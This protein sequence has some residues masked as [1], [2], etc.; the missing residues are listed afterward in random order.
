MKSFLNLGKY[1]HRNDNRDNMSLIPN[2]INRVKSK[3]YFLCCLNT[4]CC[5]C[6]CI[7]QI[8]MNHN[9]TDNRSQIRIRAKY[10]RTAVC[11]QNWQECVC[12][13]TEKLCKR[14][15]RTTGID[16]QESIV[17]HEIQCFHNSHKETTCNDCRNDRNENITKSLNQSLYRICSGSCNLLQIFLTAL[18]NSGNLNKFIV[19]LIDNSC[20]QN[21]LHLSL[22][23]ENAFNTF[24]I[25]NIF[26]VSLRIITDNQSK[27][28]GTMSRGNNILFFTNMVVYFLGCL[29]VI[30]NIL[31]LI[32]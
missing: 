3:P 19:Y 11:N 22:G 32:M 4:F 12:R 26:L 24:N 23:K 16:I 1:P 15:N 27:T 25:L 17:N 5:N 6:P 14:I 8:W 2:H 28:C 9:H 18:R 10:F 13:I 20:S 29:S 7:L 31:P 21:D 30:H